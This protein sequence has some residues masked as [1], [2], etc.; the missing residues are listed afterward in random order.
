MRARS[1]ANGP[2]GRVHA[3]TALRAELAFGHPLLAGSD[4]WRHLDRK[5][6][7]DRIFVA[8]DA[9]GL[10]VGRRNRGERLGD[11]V[12]VAGGLPSAVPNPAPRPA[13]PPHRG[14][15]RRRPA[16]GRSWKL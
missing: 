5:F 2:A 3:T 6:V 15:A 1:A 16:V 10:R 14:L 12:E 9:L 11:R 8:A 13:L 4:E 7:V